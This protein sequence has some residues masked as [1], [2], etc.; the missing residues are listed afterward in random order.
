[1]TGP[2]ARPEI[3]EMFQM[4]RTTFDKLL[5]WIGTSLGVALLIAGGLL[6]WGSAYVHNTVQGQLAAQQISFPRLPR[7]RTPRPEP[8]S[9]PA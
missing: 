7:S 1:M 6:V 3:R 2:E 8:R 5:G 4:R 9:R